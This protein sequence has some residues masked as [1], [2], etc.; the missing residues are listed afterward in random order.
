MFT[1]WFVISMNHLS[2]SSTWLHWSY[3]TE[4][5]STYVICVCVCFII[6]Y[7]YYIWCWDIENYLT[8]YIQ[9]L[10]INCSLVAN[11]SLAIELKTILTCKAKNFTHILLYLNQTNYTSY[12]FRKHLSIFIWGQDK[13]YDSY[14]YIQQMC[15]WYFSI[16]MVYACVYVSEYCMQLCMYLAK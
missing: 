4:C 11:L 10:V 15:G 13:Y 8:N 6:Y 9:S 12:T 7:H 2:R 16:F 14:L 1:F 5:M 3:A